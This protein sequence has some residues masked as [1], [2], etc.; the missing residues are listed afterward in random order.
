VAVGH[1]GIFN[2]LDVVRICPYDTLHGT[3]CATVSSPAAVADEE[4]ARV[5]IHVDEII[6]SL[7]ES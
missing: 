5:L 3:A 4:L 7:A 6:D 2:R 1:A